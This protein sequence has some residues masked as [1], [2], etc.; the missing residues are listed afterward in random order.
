MSIFDSTTSINTTQGVKYAT[1]EGGEFKLPQVS[2]VWK[3]NFITQTPSKVV[4]LPLG[5][6]F[7]VIFSTLCVV[8]IILLFITLYSPIPFLSVKFAIFL[9][10]FFGAFAGELL[11]ARKIRKDG[12]Y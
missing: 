2:G 7:L 10:L 6:V 4:S 3:P 1:V 12:Q 11:F 5:G 8:S 9:T